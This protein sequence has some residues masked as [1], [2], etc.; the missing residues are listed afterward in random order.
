MLGKHKPENRFHDLDEM[1]ELVTFTEGTGL[2]G[3]K[4]EPFKGTTI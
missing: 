1:K 4:Y 3:M 2:I